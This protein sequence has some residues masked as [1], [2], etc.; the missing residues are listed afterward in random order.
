M[1]QTTGQMQKTN[2]GKALAQAAS[3][4]DTWVL[5]VQYATC[6][7]IELTIN[8]FAVSYYVDSFGKSLETA[9]LVGSL[10]GMMNLFARAMGGIISDF[11]N[12]NLTAL[13][14]GHPLRAR[15]VAHS[16]ILIYEGLMLLAFSR[17]T[18]FGAAV[19]VMVLFSLGVQCAEGTTFSLV[20]YV[21]PAVTGAV[22]GI[23]GAGGNVGAMCWGFIFLWGP[24]NDRSVLLILGF[25]VFAS[26]FLS[27]LLRFPRFKRASA[28]TIK[29]VEMQS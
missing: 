14:K 9:S 15:I 12:K 19:G 21:D 13:N 7:G 3:N 29:E 2:P 16:V 17:C 25:I 20:P 5:F 28:E 6:F 8:N 27:V 1:L 23:V 22:S 24:S 18:T 4:L 26:G 11:V 10:F